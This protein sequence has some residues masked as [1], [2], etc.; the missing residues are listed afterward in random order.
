MR[1][2]LTLDDDVHARLESEARR[3][4]KS[5]KEVV[6]HYLRLGLTVRRTLKPPV[7]FR[8]RARP[9][10]LREGL[11]VASTAGLIEDIEGPLHR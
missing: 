3:E 4:G 7:V 6:N 8:V 9:M 2:T 5:F 10:G 11:S 1:T